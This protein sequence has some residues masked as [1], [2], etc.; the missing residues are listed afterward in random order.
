MTYENMCK[1]MKENH[2]SVPTSARSI[3]NGSRKLI[4][5]DISDEIKNALELQEFNGEV[6]IA[7]EGN[8]ASPYY[9]VRYTKENHFLD[10]GFFMVVDDS[11]AKDW[12]VSINGEYFK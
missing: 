5:L 12:I 3:W 8:V 7:I 9:P 10:S 11:I 2:E 1:M 4:R 6:F